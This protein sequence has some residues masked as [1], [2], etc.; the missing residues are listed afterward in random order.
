MVEIEMDFVIPEKMTEEGNA[1]NECRF[2]I[3]HLS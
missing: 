2:S 3:G 1:V